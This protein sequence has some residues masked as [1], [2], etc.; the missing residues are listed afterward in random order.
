MDIITKEKWQDGRLKSNH[1]NKYIKI[2]DLGDFPGG[3][4]VKTLHFHCE[5]TDLIPIW[6]TKISHA[7]WHSQ[8]IK[9]KVNDL[10]TAI[11]R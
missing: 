4:T 3:P 7:V 11:K 5:S 1:I 2:N 6:G 10:N 8:K 9:I